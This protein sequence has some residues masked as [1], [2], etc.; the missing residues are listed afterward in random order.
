M[1]LNDY[2]K[3]I[4]NNAG[5]ILKYERKSWNMSRGRLARLAYTDKETIEYIEKGYVCMMTPNV[6]KNVA[7]V[8]QRDFRIFLRRELNAD[9]LADFCE[10]SYF[11]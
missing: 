5:D 10:L 9:E 1:D 3:L 8:L 6:L 4:R 7:E 2:Y 11:K